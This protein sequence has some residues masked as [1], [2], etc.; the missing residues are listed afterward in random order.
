M[1]KILLN[2]SYS[3]NSG[4]F[5]QDSYIKNKVFSIDEKLNIHNVIADIIRQDGME[6]TYKNKP[7]TNVFIDDK[8]GNQKAIGY[9][10]RGKTE[11]FNDEKGKNEIALFDVWVEIS[12]VENYKI[13]II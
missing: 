5:W 7:M 10:Y 1:Q 2:V 8:D 6:I 3:D 4:K 9:I 12:K 13:E 11:I